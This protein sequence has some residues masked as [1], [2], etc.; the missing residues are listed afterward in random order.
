M[1]IIGHG[2]DIVPVARIAEM[3]ERH[4][5]HFL[6]R[7]FTPGERAYADASARR[8][9]EHLA[10]RF[11][12]KEATL[13]A[14]GTGWRNGIAWTDIEVVLEPSGRPILALHGEAARAATGAG[15]RA[16]HVSISHTDDT[17]IASVIGEG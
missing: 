6:E 2:V 15:I 7:V 3:V 5:A 11:A 16:W 17:A 14:L 12:V 13:K 10:G 8:R 9:M 4:A 1:R